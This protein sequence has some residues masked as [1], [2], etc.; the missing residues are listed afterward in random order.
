MSNQEKFKSKQYLKFDLS[1]KDLHDNPFKQFDNWYKEILASKTEF[2]NAMILSTSSSD[3]KPSSRVV[4]LKYYDE[5][6]FV[7]YSNSESRK[8]MDIKEN[9]YASVCFWWQ[10]Y[11]RQVILEGKVELL[12]D[13]VVDSYFKSR[14]RGSQISASIS[15]QSK[16]VESRYFLEKLYK[17]FDLQHSGKE[18]KRP[19]FWKGYIIKPIR[20]DFWQGSKNRLHNRFK[21][22]LL[23]NNRWKID[24]LY[25]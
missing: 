10:V 1:R 23:K 4:L 24:R 7:F 14:P 15:Q 17:D 3:S 21:Y 9:P 22:S 18:I 19:D 12:P 16:V 11:E 2:P 25:P 8:G 13:K 5:K 6:G 20:F